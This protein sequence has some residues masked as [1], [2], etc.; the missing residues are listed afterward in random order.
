MV[1]KPKENSEQGGFTLLIVN[2]PSLLRL[3]RLK[4]DVIF[5]E[6]TGH[7]LDMHLSSYDG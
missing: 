6:A 5:Y 2:I 7:A 4:A 1:F 3:L